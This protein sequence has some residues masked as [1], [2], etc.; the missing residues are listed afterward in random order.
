MTAAVETTPVATPA[1]SGEDTLDFEAMMLICCGH[2]A[3]QLVWSAQRLGL[4]E[5]VAAQPG[6]APAALQR[7]LGLADRPFRIV[8]TGMIALRL[9]LRT[10]EGGLRLAR[11]AREMLVRGSPGNWIDA[12]GWQ[13]CIV[14]PGEQDLL[15]SLRE[16][17]NAGLER[18][19]APGEH[20]YARLANDPE[21]ER[22]FHAAMSALSS[23]AGRILAAARPF[24]G[25]RHLV[26][27][28]GGDGTNAISAAT[29]HPG[30]RITVFDQP[31]V[32]ARAGQRAAAAGLGARIATHPGDLFTTPFPAGIDAALMAHLVTIWSRERNLELMGRI[33]AALPPGGRFAVYGMMGVDDLSGPMS[34]ALGSP[35]FLSIATGEGMMYTVGEVAA[36]VVEAGFSGIE[37][38]PLERDHWLI[39]ATRP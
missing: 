6:I 31:T 19:P 10:P 3:F 25:C 13:G 24:A 11:L 36:M 16:D 35:Y 29:T 30:L 34:T 14:Y 32:C 1:C 2:T 7:E 28:G 23:S 20:L 39:T 37:R 21:L 5:A 4:F 27:V 18:F 17:R 22:V 38:H 8:L 12:L 15:R 26:D 33:R 9:A